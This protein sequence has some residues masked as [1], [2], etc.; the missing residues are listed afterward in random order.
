MA[1]FFAQSVCNLGPLF[2]GIGLLL[3]DDLRAGRI[4]CWMLPSAVLILAT[5]IFILNAPQLRQARSETV[6]LNHPSY[7]R[8]QHVSPYLAQLQRDLEI[9]LQQ[10]RFDPAQ[11]VV[12]VGVN[13]SL[14]LT[15]LVD[16]PS[17]GAP[18]TFGDANRE[19]LGDVS[20]AYLWNCAL[21]RLGLQHPPRRIFGLNL[22]TLSPASVACLAP[23]A[24]ANGQLSS[25]PG[26]IAVTIL[27]EVSK[28]G[29]GG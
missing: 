20:K 16:A 7:L 25:E 23:Y 27:R 1:V 22:H 5:T 24:S 2:L 8:G 21:F 17:L 11:D 4:A 3:A 10:A 12:A 13:E 14:V 28:N 19:A 29:G 15:M 26:P 6:E 18:F 9:R